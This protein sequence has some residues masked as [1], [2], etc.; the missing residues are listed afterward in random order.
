MLLEDT[1][2]ALPNV[3]IVLME[4]FIL[5]GSATRERYE[6]FLAVKDYA[7]VV[8]KLA[9]EYNAVFVPLQK[10]LDEAAKKHGAEAY[11]ADGVHPGVAGSH[12]IADEWLKTFHREIER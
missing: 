10:V 1:K 9:D 6:D 11:L 7:Q 5:E 4:P 3:K 2:A 12:V 8:K